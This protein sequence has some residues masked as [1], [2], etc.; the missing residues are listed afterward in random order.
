MRCFLIHVLRAPL[1]WLALLCGP[2]LASTSGVV[3]SQIYGG[4]GSTYA[5]D[6]VELFNAGTVAVNIT[7]WSVQ[8]S[9]A[10]G[11]GLFSGN[12][13]T[14]VTGSLA[15]GE[16]FLVKLGTS[17][18]GAALPAADATG[19]T[20][21]SGT[22]GKVI[23]ANVST[24]LACNGG[25]T[26][27]GAAELA[28]I[29]DLVGYGT[30]DFREG[31][32]APA[33][34]ATTALLRNLGGC[35][36]TNQ[37]GSDFVAAAPAPR[38]RATPLAPCGGGS[39]NLAIAPACPANL[40]V[41]SGA[42]VSFPLA[43]S[44]G[45][46]IVN[47]AVFT[48]GN[49]AGITLS[50]FA[51]ANAAGGTARVQL[52]LAGSVANG[53]YPLVVQ[54]GNN[55][56]QT[57]S[58]A[59]N[60]TVAPLAPAFT[61]IYTIQ[62]SGVV[63][64]LTGTRTTRGVVTKV[65]N[66]GY[67]I[68]DPTG[69]G[70]PFTSDGIFVF[71]STTPYVSVGHAVQISGT[72]SEFNTGAATNTLTAANPVTEFSNLTGT[73]FTGTGNIVPT[74]ISLPVAN[75]GD[76]ERYEGMLVS[77]GT[78]LTASQNYFQGRYGQVTLAAGGRLPKPTNVARPGTPQA[79]SLQDLNARAS[80]LLD[81]GT[82]LQNPNPIPYL[83]Q[84]NTLRAGDTL[85]AGVTGVI[86]YGLA[87]SDNEGLAL[88]RIHPTATPLFTRANPRSATPPAVGG[89][90]RVASFNVLNYFTTFSNGATA[91]GGS[92][93]GCLPSNSTADCRGADNAAEFTRQRDKIVRA[94]AALNADVVG[95]MEIQRNGSTA[96]QNLV[97]GLNSFIGAG[98]YAVVP[99]PAFV[100]T[101]AIKVAL[102]YKPAVLSLSGAALSDSDPIHNRA[103][104]AQTFR[105][106]NGAKFSVIVNHFKSKSCSGATGADADQGDGQGCYNDR[107]TRQA[108][109][110]LGFI[111]SVKLAA[112]DDDVLVIGDLNAYAMEDPVEALKTGGLTDQVLRFVGSSGYSYVFDGEAGYLDHAL[113]TPSLAAQ[114]SAAAHWHINA[115]EP[116]VIDYNTENKPQD[117]YAVSPYRA[118][119]HDPVLIGIAL[120]AGT[121]PQTISFGALGGR[122]LDQSPFNVA[123][124]SS[125]GLAVAFSSLTAAVCGVAASTVT[126]SGVGTCSIAADQAGNAIFLPAPQLVQ[127]FNVI[128]GQSQTISFAPIAPQVLGAA[129]FLLS[130]SAS[131]G[132]PVAL[133][134]Q[135]PA[136]CSV[137]GQTVNLLATGTCSLI[138]QQ[139]GDN[140][141]LPATAV[142]Q[143]FTV[144]TQVGG[145]G[146]NGD[147]P[148]PAWALVLLAAG[149][150][151]GLSARRSAADRR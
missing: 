23:L 135:T 132:L 4:N 29:V 106:V 121:Q 75:A 57:A 113:A 136:V 77:I 111:N 69:D 56:S 95:L 148:L 54:F 61:P 52:A 115:D 49:A 6:Y 38:N 97:D 86:D 94:I 73:V 3:I 139:G 33:A 78:P 151:R 50:G 40:A 90:H 93:Q 15:A 18:T 81:D 128:Q 27:C 17:A 5:S 64:L 41:A 10:T 14:V 85:P 60:L 100:G 30:A 51:A 108:S 44:D 91:G 107:R 67:Y 25:T 31:T 105:A 145:G 120:S 28:Q 42:V 58:C 117:L 34:T 144:G 118:S 2:A 53:S 79:A 124:S 96:A 55:D 84:D 109:A 127:S 126:L 137:A 110:L 89:T 20:N 74:P 99:E 37:N 134:T 26:P 19:T 63:S 116:S 142:V 48:G 9:S 122:R 146:D 76:L 1:L 103:P 143:S 147:V 45:D 68:Q 16:Y 88:Y 119:D 59:I 112:A 39:G 22:S 13:V 47:S 66:N 62:G 83:G 130:P 35:S 32:A 8:Y 125:A 70:D 21:L 131:S 24:G 114:I 36:D 87:T 46:S 92:G 101:D 150:A 129:P 72:V 133:A 65:N 141:Y 104:L 11:S 140:T 138:A 149:L 71:T 7:G 82:S 123:A 80:L 102:I 12:G 43:A 98:T